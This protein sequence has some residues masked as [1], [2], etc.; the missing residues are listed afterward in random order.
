MSDKKIL[1]VTADFPPMIGGQSAY[2]WSVWSRFLDKAVI[3]AP[4]PGA[5]GVGG[6][7]GIFRLYMP[8]GR[9]FLPRAVK[10]LLLT[11]GT[12]M[13]V[14]LTRPAFMV[15]G[16]A[17]AGGIAVWIASK[18]SGIRYAVTIHGGDVL[19]WT[20][21]RVILDSIIK[22]AELLICNS[23]PTAKLISERYGR[24][25]RTTVV[26]PPVPDAFTVEAPDKKQCRRRL[27][28]P[29]DAVIVLTVAR[30]YERKGIGLAIRSVSE[31]LKKGKNIIYVM[32]GDGPERKKLSEFADMLGIEPSRV[33]F[34]GAV[35]PEKLVSYYKAADIFLLTPFR[36]KDDVE[37]F[38]VVYLEAQA[39]GLPVV[40]SRSGG[41]TDAVKENETAILVE[42]GNNEDITSALLRLA[43]DPV[44]RE[45][46]GSAGRKWALDNFNADK[47][48]FALWETL[49]NHAY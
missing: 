47:T 30:L 5:A 24:N 44:L 27:G 14:L 37:G 17:T 15:S 49:K 4:A 18:L 39:S 19:G 36:T 31:M 7:A 23:G 42:P 43:D 2:L 22:N 34:A 8:H 45:K 21:P 6:G 11:I 20:G 40:A 3:I 26:N 46:M 1:F 32:V 33:L 10:T 12:I 28:L 35:N 13:S 29:D 9:G 25:E 16:Q 38:G 48:A 41:V